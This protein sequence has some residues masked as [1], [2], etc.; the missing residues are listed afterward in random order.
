MTYEDT[1][2]ETLCIAESPSQPGT[3]CRAWI[4]KK[5][6]E[7]GTWQFRVFFVDYGDYS[8]LPLNKLRTLPTNFINRLPFQAIAC[9]LHGVGPKTASGSWTKEDIDFF[10]S[11]T[12]DTKGYMHE[13]HAHAKFKEF[14]NEVTKGPHYRISLINRQETEPQNL[15]EQMISQ[16]RAIPLENDEDFLAAVRCSTAHKKHIEAEEMKKA[17][18]QAQ[19]LFEDED[20][21]KFDISPSWIEEFALH[22]STGTEKNPNP[23]SSQTNKP[24]DAVSALPLKKINPKPVADSDSSLTLI[25]HT[26]PLKDKASHFPTT[27]WWQNDEN[28]NIT[29]F[30]DNVSA[31]N[32]ELT[33]D[34]LSFLAD[35]NGLRYIECIFKI[36]FVLFLFFNSFFS[37]I[38]PT[39]NQSFLLFALYSL[40]L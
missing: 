23:Q 1:H 24:A 3:W 8:T 38:K 22:C 37:K 2:L 16:Q 39:Y 32:L 36:C 12:R 14:I 10:V 31:Y 5:I 9:S 19:Q 13:L 26:M 11:L 30:V 33:E 28:I 20:E 34:H 6:V 25:E 27:K 21:R 7:D 18:R 35:V 15:A 29:F 40:L 17:T 4:K